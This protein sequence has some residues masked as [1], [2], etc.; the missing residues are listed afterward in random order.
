[1]NKLTLTAVLALSALIALPQSLSA[2]GK[3]GKKVI[4]ATKIQPA[5]SAVQIMGS[6]DA[7]KN[8]S[9]V[10]LLRLDGKKVDTLAV[11]PISKAGKFVF[12]RGLTV[13]TLNLVDLKAGRNA[14]SLILEPGVHV[15]KLDAKYG[16]NFLSPSSRL[17]QARYAH[18]KEYNLKIEA[19]IKTLREAKDEEARQ[20]AYEAYVAVSREAYETL[21]KAHPGNALGGQALLRLIGGMIVPEIADKKALIALASPALQATPR[22][23]RVIKMVNALEATAVGKPYIDVE[24]VND[25]K[26]VSKLSDFVSKGHYTLID[27]WASWCGPCRRA[28][29][30]LKK[31]YEQYGKEGLQIVGLAVWDKWD[32]HLKAVADEELPWPQIFA[33]NATEPYGVNGIPQIMLIA[34]NGTIVARDLHGE[35]AIA[36][37][38]EAE[39]AK[40]GGKL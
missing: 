21:F 4:P 16:E 39:K 17:N 13:D 20:K 24:G 31:I 34:P 11:A 2:Q 35:E 18:D 9:E 6:V 40:N 28:M 7:D 25:D 15:V 26:Q 27:F 32:D 23:E 38:L 5:K 14:M 29:P 36:K 37:V 3:K 10:Y 8:L 30:G 12:D 22:V 19:I 33:E 1:M